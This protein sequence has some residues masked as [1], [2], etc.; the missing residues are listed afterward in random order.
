MS[1]TSVNIS[2]SLEQILSIISQLP[3]TDKLTISKYIAEDTSQEQ[4]IAHDIEQGLKD[5]KQH[6]EGKVDLQTLD[7][8]IDEL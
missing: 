3:M 4:R 8:L 5:V 1:T 2:F 7:Q 6:E